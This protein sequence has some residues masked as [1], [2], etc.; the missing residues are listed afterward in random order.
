MFTKILFI[1][2][3]VIAIFADYRTNKY[4]KI[5]DKTRAVINLKRKLHIPTII[6]ALLTGYGLVVGE[7]D[8]FT[9]SLALVFLL[10]VIKIS[11]FNPK[12]IV[13]NTNNVAIS[14]GEVPLE[15]ISVFTVGPKGELIIQVSGL[16]RV[17]K[18]MPRSK[19]DY[20]TILYCAEQL[21][22][23]NAREVIQK[24]RLA[25]IAANARGAFRLHGVIKDYDWGGKHYLAQELKLPEQQIAEIWYGTHPQGQGSLTISGEQVAEL[26]KRFYNENPG[27]DPIEVDPTQDYNVLLN[28][29]LAYGQPLRAGEES[30]ADALPFLFKI[31]D[32]ARPLSIQ[33]HPDKETAAQG[34]VQEEKLKIELS[35]AKRTFKDKNHKPEFGMAL[36]PMYLLHGF[37]PKEQVLA[38]LAHKPA[39]TQLREFIEQ[40]D[41]AQAY[42]ELFTKSK[43]ELKDLLASHLDTVLELYDPLIERQLEAQDIVT[44]QEEHD[45][46]NVEQA[47]LDPDYWL[48]FTYKSLCMT[49]DDLDVGLIS[50]YFFNLVKLEAYQGIYQQA[51]VPHAYLRGRL[52]EVMANSDNVVRGGLTNKHINT[53]LYLRLVDT[54][55]VTPKVYAQGDYTLP[56]EE[57][58][59]ELIDFTDGQGYQNNNASIWYVLEGKGTIEF[60]DQ[61]RVANKLEVQA[62]QAV[63]V[64]VERTIK[65][66]GQAKVVIASVK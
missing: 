61:N 10:V 15:A 41:L 34:F 43:A 13:V 24:H 14:F 44:Y 47:N 29:N 59:Y 37:A 42:K 20:D 33:I 40:R 63:F 2:C 27:Q 9:Q 56:S 4:L 60:F 1:V 25:Q 65:F 58:T 49:P 21:N 32:V 26:T 39:L 45:V 31:L 55:P 48:A 11:Y 22:I 62:N 3:L 52:V 66:T 64:S 30:K 23:G 57:F 16:N 35:S 28:Y 5:T 6:F 7:Y 54:T 12:R 19:E 51:N 17:F 50:F 36:T 8:V 18:F 46:L 53:E 38:K